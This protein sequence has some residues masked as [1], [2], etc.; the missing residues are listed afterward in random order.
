MKRFNICTNYITKIKDMVVPKGALYGKDRFGYWVC[1]QKE[2][3]PLDTP[4]LEMYRWNNDK[5]GWILLLEQSETVEYIVQCATKFDLWKVPIEYPKFTGIHSISANNDKVVRKHKIQRITS[6]YDY[7]HRHDHKQVPL[8][9]WETV[10]PMSYAEKAG[11]HT[12][13]RT[14]W[15]KCQYTVE[16]KP[17]IVKNVCC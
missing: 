15:R 3:Y 11:K 5:M 8:D 17:Y 16:S 2:L 7:D 9:I 6:Q 14:K 10:A 13:K 12:L 4:T 1:I